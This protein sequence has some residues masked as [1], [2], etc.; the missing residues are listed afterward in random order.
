VFLYSQTHILINLFINRHVLYFSLCNTFSLKKNNSHNFLTFYQFSL[1]NINIH[2]SLFSSLDLYFGHISQFRSFTLVK[3]VI[4][5]LC[6]VKMSAKRHI[7]PYLTP[8]VSLHKSAF[9]FKSNYRKDKNFHGLKIPYERFWSEFY[10]IAKGIFFYYGLRIFL[11]WEIRFP[12]Y[13]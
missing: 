4:L 1:Q 2:K 6:P 7:S 11:P 8:F 10:L 3:Y 5:E 13:D 12:P 9:L